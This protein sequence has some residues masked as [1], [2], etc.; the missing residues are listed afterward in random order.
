[1]DLN[2]DEYYHHHQQQQQSHP[3][4]NN[5]QHDTAAAQTS[6]T[7]STIVVQGGPLQLTIALLQVSENLFASYS[8]CHHW[9]ALI[10]RTIGVRL[11]WENLLTD[12]NAL[13]W[14]PLREMSSLF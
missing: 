14:K 8:F 1:M 13:K 9:A 11:C 10:S 6:T 4:D 12:L 2:E 7:I 3:N 5:N